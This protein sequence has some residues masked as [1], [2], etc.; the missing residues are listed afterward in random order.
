VPQTQVV[1]HVNGEGGKGLKISIH[2]DASDVAVV[3]RELWRHA[4]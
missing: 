2:G 1:A 3:I 4:Q